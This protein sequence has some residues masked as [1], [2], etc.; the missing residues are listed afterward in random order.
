MRVMP[1]QISAKRA[2][3][4]VVM[5]A[6]AA[7][8]RWCQLAVSELFLTSLTPLAELITFLAP[9]SCLTESDLIEARTEARHKLLR[10]VVFSPEFMGGMF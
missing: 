4:Q 7:N 5:D 9:I 1:A 2:R 10:I 8:L 6:L 3:L